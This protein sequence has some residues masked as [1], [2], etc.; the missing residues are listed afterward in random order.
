MMMEVVSTGSDRIGDCCDVVI[1]GAVGA[2]SWLGGL[3]IDPREKEP[4]QRD[5]RTGVV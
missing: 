5:C 1:A 3:E 2:A 4:A